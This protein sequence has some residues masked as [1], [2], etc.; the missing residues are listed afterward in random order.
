MHS[1]IDSKWIFKIKFVVL[2]TRL[3]F[4]SNESGRRIIKRKIL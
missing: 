1:C 3:P 2:K 4:K